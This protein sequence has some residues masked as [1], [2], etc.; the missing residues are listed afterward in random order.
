MTSPLHGIRV[1][2]LITDGFEQ[3]ELTEPRKALEADGAAV[4]VVS[5]EKTD[6]RGWN[7]GEWGEHVRVDCRLET[8][9]AA[10]YDALLLPGGVINSDHLR[11]NQTVRQWVRHFFAAGKPIAVICHGAWP[12]IDA[13]VVRGLTIT[14]YPSMKADLQNAA[15]GYPR[16]HQ[17]LHERALEIAVANLALLAG[18]LSGI[19][20]SPERIPA[21]PD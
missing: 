12:L 4:D 2:A 3:V 6:V 16:V 11:T 20:D 8:A 18:Q 7:R 5:P 14:S 13:G 9:H 15:G 19:G 1:A 10:D 17:N 21:R